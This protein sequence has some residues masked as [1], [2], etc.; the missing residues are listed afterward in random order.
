MG[1][2]E[3]SKIDKA[4]IDKSRGLINQAQLDYFYMTYNYTQDEVIT[5]IDE[6][7]KLNLN[8]SGQLNPEDL[9]D[10][11]PFHFSPFGYHIL[12]A[13]DLKVDQVENKSKDLIDDND[14]EKDKL[15]LKIKT[16]SK[17]D[18]NIDQNITTEDQ[19]S[20]LPKIGEEIKQIKQNKEGMVGIQ[21]F[22]YY[23][24]L[25]SSH[26]KLVEKAQLYFKLFDFDNDGKISPSDIIVYLENLEKDTD[27]VLSDTKKYLRE[28]RQMKKEDFL[29]DIDE[30]KSADE[31]KRIAN[32]IIKEACGEEKNYLDFFD[33]RN[34][35]LNMQFVP[36][37]SNPLYLEELFDDDY[38]TNKKNEN[39]NKNELMLSV[40]NDDINKEEKE[41]ENI[42]I[43][44]D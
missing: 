32:L 28:K 18:E 39:K 15:K 13:L 41:T 22:M 21:D 44:E 20:D 42:G 4:I 33:F 27:T 24:Y 30:I 29:S 5:I 25:F 23:V 6:Y 36:E 38:R 35:F 14:N 16:K 10:F 26:V 17:K 8:E 43:H 40:K 2:C 31:N 3:G 19:I 34:M 12:D 7:Q 9:I 11:P 37:Y 1:C